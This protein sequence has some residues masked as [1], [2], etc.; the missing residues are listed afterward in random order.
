[1]DVPEPPQIVFEQPAP[2]A[3]AART[4][5]ALRRVLAPSSAPGPGWHV[6]VRIARDKG[7]LH[8]T[9]EIVDR[10]GAPVATRAIDKAGS[11]CAGLGR[12]MGVWASLVLDAEVQRAQEQAPIPPPPPPSPQTAWPSPAPP[13]EKPSPESELFLAHPAEERDVEIGLGSLA[14]TG[15]GTGLLV[16]GTLFEVSEVGAGW[17]LRPSLGVARTLTELFPGADGYGSL[18]M[19]RF[20]ACK[21][22]PGNYLERRGLQLDLCAGPELGFLEVSGSGSFTASQTLPLLALGP[23][24]DFRGELGNALSVLVRG[25][26]DLNL[27]SATTADGRISEDRLVARAEVGLSW[28][29]R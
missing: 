18:G 17:Y 23:S 29:L 22:I 5:E 4:E 14:M 10:S 13:P 16:G 9:G 19:A 7:S 11:D 1:M 3:D 21:R 15:T 25:V 20:D 28:R 2:C 8:A 6:R 24:I 27:L 26:A 12:A